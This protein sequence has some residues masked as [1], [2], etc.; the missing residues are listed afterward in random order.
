VRR[1]A[2]VR[3]AVLPTPLVPAPRLSDALRREVWIKRDDLTGFALGG[4]KVRTLEVLIADALDTRCDHL[5]G[6]GGPGSNLGPALAAAA[7]TAQLDCTIVLYGDEPAD[8]HPNLAMMRALGAHVVF[9]GDADRG[10]TGAHAEAEARRLLA[11]GHRPYVV[12]RGAACGL[13]ATAYALAAEELA[14][15]LRCTPRHVVVAVGSGGTAA[16]LLAGWTAFDLPGTLA[17]VAVSRPLDE[18]A[19]EI[20][21][22]STEAAAILGVPPPRADRLQLID[23]LGDGFGRADASTC[24]GAR[25][26]LRTEGLLADETYVARAV[27]ALDGLDAPV[28]L[29]HTGGWLGAVGDAMGIAH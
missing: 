10:A 17:G 11:R 19:A 12:P 1:P 29:W 22:L 6:C 14:S 15:Q 18:T 4:N 16:G 20:T 13:G 23:G 25:L 3:L 9:T 7:A 27:A 26:A 28:I 21:R 2:R 8:T 24:A 5:V